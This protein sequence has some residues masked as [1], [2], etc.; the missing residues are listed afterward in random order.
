MKGPGAFNARG[1]L[2]PLGMTAF[3][4]FPPDYNAVVNLP[5]IRH[6]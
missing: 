5:R 1:I 3:V 4:L 6:D 2:A